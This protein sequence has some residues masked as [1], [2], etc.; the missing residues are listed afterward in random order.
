MGA[1]HDGYVGRTIGSR[2]VE[3]GSVIERLR[4]LAVEDPERVAV[5]APGRAPASRRELVEQIAATAAQIRACGIGPDGRVAVVLPDGPELAVAFLGISAAAGCAPL[6]PGSTVAELRFVLDDL[7]ADAVVV[8]ASGHA[9]AEEAAAAGGTPVLHLHPGAAAGTATLRRPDGSPLAPAAPPTDAVAP[10]LDAVAPSLD[11]VAPSLDAVAPSLDA[12]ALLLHTSGTTARPKLVALRHRQVLGSAA[13]V[14]A[15]LALGSDDRSL[16]VM[17]LFHVHG[18][19]AALLAPLLVGGEVVTPTD[20]STGELLRLVESTA[21]TWVTAVPTALAALLE[22]VEAAVST[23][24]PPDHRLRL[25][26]SC[27]AALPPVV[28]AG[29]ERALGI[30]VLEAYGMTEG[31]H[32]IASN[33][34]PPAVRKPGSVG[35]STGPEIAVVDDQGAPVPPGAVGEVV[36]RGGSVIDGYVANPAADAEAFRDGWFRTGDLGRIDEDG[37]L[38]LTGR[39]KELVNRAGEKIAPREVEEALAEHP[40][41]ATVV[42]FAVPDTRLGEQVAAAVV[43][44]APV[45]E[46]ELRL[47]AAERLASHKVPR[48]VV[49]CEEI[50]KGPTGKLQRRGLAERFELADLDDRPPA[51]PP[52]AP[53]GPVEDLLAELWTEVLA[54]P[55]DDANARFLDLGG[56]SLAALRLLARIR[57]ELQIEVAM[58]DLF[59]APTVA[60]QARI[61]EDA[62]MSG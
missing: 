54:R 34:L 35:A 30:P 48:R 29:L 44:R 24:R 9:A 6:N 2:E 18:L 8:P 4:L 47:F 11:A 53:D 28:G 16:V 41:V 19:V 21:P 33:P 62:L 39:R 56:D 45:T 52:R 55:V 13:A 49:L 38:F 27:S 46:R 50:P 25:L 20:R 26:R 59:D 22:Q 31:A 51:G 7:G 23:G 12:V 42:V 36:L 57:N 37:Y 58:V 61:V 14:A 40:A 3:V 1:G 5:R 17:P 43:P 10:S 15:S 60:E 32:Q